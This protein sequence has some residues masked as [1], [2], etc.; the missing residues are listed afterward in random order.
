MT[1]EN[2]GLRESNRTDI[3]T[4]TSRKQTKS[5]RQ[6][7]SRS[8]ISPVFLKAGTTRETCLVSQFTV[9]KKWSD[10]T[11]SE[12]YLFRA[13][14]LPRGF[15]DKRVLCD[16]S[17]KILSNNL[18]GEAKN[19]FH[20]ALTDQQNLVLALKYCTIRQ[21][22]APPAYIITVFSLTPAFTWCIYKFRAL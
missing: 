2:T 16:E 20:Q 17:D 18:I 7:R 4:E 8:L 6:W 14:N 13:R 11:E 22:L 1:K 10:H 3:K 5:N 19:K 9:H 12:E 21:R 15:S